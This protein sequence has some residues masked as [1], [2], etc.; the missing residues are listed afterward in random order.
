MAKV[1]HKIAVSMGKGTLFGVAASFT[2]I[3]TRFITVPIIVAHLGL[4]GYGIWSIIM[5]TSAYI[6]FG[7][8]GLKSAFQKYVAAATGNGG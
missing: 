4:G 1:D 8:A 7:T 5:T 6:R 2:M 3:A